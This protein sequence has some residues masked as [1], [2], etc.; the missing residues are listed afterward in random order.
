MYLPD[1]F[2]AIT[3]FDGDLNAS[4]PCDSCVPGQSSAAI[5]ASNASTCTVCTAGQY[6]VQSG[7]GTCQTCPSGKYSIDVAATAFDSC[8]NCGVGRYNGQAA[9]GSEASCL[10]CPKGRYA[11]T[12]GMPECAPCD[13]GKFGTQDSGAQDAS[14]CSDCDVGK[15]SGSGESCIDCPLGTFSARSTPRTD[16]PCTLCEAGRTPFF[17]SINDGEDSGAVAEGCESSSGNTGDCMLTP[18]RLPTNPED[19]EPV[20][21]GSCA[22]SAL[23]DGSVVCTYMHVRFLDDWLPSVNNQQMESRSAAWNGPI[24]SQ[25]SSPLVV[26]SADGS[27]VVSGEGPFL[28]QCFLCKDGW[29]GGGSG[30][31]PAL[32]L[33]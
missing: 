19:Y 11:D 2:L 23:A 21:N 25:G 5:G 33:R 9:A 29:Y 28:E 7:R 32:P 6:N 10:L 18:S 31:C 24:V 12:G 8:R 20:T 4:T 30:E 27:Q 16:P 1:R 22:P 13:A 14:T 15:Y 26:S 17:R 3:A